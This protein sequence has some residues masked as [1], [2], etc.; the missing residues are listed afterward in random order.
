[1]LLTTNEEFLNADL[2]AEAASRE[3]Q[4]DRRIGVWTDDYSNLFQVLKF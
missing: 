1:M 3:A 2:V 4:S